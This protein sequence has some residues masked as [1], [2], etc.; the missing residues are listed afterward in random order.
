ML[1]AVPQPFEER[2][3]LRNRN[4]RR[5]WQSQTATS[6]VQVALICSCVLIAG[7]SGSGDAEIAKPKAETEG[8]RNEA[9]AA[10][11]E[12]E[13]ARAT[14]VAPPEPKL[15]REQAIANIENLCA[16]ID[17]S[18]FGS[19]KDLKYLSSLT[20]HGTGVN[21]TGVSH[22]EAI[23]SLEGL[24]LIGCPITGDGLKGLGAANKSLPA[25]QVVP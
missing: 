15:S 16:Q 18:G 1:R 9:L 7:C 10:K 3:R 17:G 20:P 24:N 8:A 4:L 5:H 25:V 6:A 21:D 13:K 14:P 11:V 23:W 22:L 12:L 19:L 2:S